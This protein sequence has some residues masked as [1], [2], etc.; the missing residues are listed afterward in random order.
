MTKRAYMAQDL[1]GHAWLIRA[2][3]PAYDLAVK[4]SPRP[5]VLPK[6]LL[7]TGLI[8]DAE[9]A[10]RLGNEP[11]TVAAQQRVI[12]LGKAA[13]ALPDDED[14]QA[15]FILATQA[16]DCLSTLGRSKIDSSKEAT[17]GDS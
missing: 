12:R 6:G 2:G 1:D 13:L 9:L 5:I 7:M 16:L 11:F 8:E 3:D 10:A 4:L 15:A 17:I 14:V